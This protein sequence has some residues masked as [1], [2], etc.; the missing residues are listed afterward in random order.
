MQARMGGGSA[1]MV[2]ALTL[3]A[4]VSAIQPTPA[5]AQAAADQRA[6]DT[7]TAA[8]VPA[9]DKAS[10]RL[11]L[12]EHE[13]QALYEQAV[14]DSIVTEPDEVSGRLFPISSHNPELIWRDGPSGREVL[15]V[16]WV[17]SYKMARAVD[18][19][20]TG[21][22]AP[23]TVE[24]A[25][26]Y[27]G[28]AA[29]TLRGGDGEPNYFWVTPVPQFQRF[30]AGLGLDG[31]DLRIRLAQY[32]GLPIESAIGP[33]AESRFVVELWVSPDNLFRP[34]ADPEI[35]DAACRL[36][37]DPLG[38]FA[39]AATLPA[40]HPYRA[41]FERRHA[42]SYEGDWRFPWTR[43]GYTYDWG[44]SGDEVGG[45]EYVIFED[46]EF[47]IA[48]VDTPDAYCQP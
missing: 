4:A 29:T 7:S 34:C 18:P 15:V 28:Q 24:D 14:A 43:L 2:A 12:D 26:P 5:H 9:T 13:W 22:Q 6:A 11:H 47:S 45:S 25:E 38:R 48:A 35:N 21:A 37:P 3:A 44:D 10:D 23:T 36:D 8:A 20:V 16:S 27:V 42:L 39:A 32:L 31:R 41:W 30:C 19:A 17:S 40:D 33:Y 46:A 1:A